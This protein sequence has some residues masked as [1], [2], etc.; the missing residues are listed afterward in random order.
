ME[1]KNTTQVEDQA[2]ESQL[3]NSLSVVELEERFELTAAAV[4]A[5]R[6]TISDVAL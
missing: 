2:Q 1:P 6:C 3:D 4:E 5:D